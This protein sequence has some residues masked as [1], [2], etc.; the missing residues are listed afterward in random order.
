M[1]ILAFSPNDFFFQGDCATEIFTDK[2]SEQMHE[3][4]SERNISKDGMSA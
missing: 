1:Y 2:T 3:L 4:V